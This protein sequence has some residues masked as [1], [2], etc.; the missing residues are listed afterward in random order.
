MKK[1]IEV[2]DQNFESIFENNNNILIDFYA[3]WCGPCKMIS[4]ILDEL[5]NDESLKTKIA[6]INIDESPFLSNL[7]KIRSVPSIFYYKNGEIVSK[8]TLPPTK[9]NLINF[10]KDNE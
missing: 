5:S 7:A 6:K 10:I 8:L 1:I 3:P 2:N 9:N 4:P